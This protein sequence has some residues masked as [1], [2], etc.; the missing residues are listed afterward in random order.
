[1][2][3][4]IDA[5][6]LKAGVLQTT[7]RLAANPT[8]GRI[9]PYVDTRLIRDVAVE[10][11]WEQFG[12]S[13]ELRSDEP[14]GRGGGGTAPTSIRYFLSGIAFCLQVWYAKGAAL[15]G[16]ELESLTLR[17]EASFDMRVEYKLP[18]TSEHDYLLAS[19]VVGSP[20]DAAMV[21]AM[22]DE[23]HER[24]PLSSLVQRSLPVYRRLTH[25]G[26]LILDT[27]PADLAAELPGA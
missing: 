23:A 4:I 11:R 9:R 12:K 16:C 22:A 2:E 14:S 27:L 25:N 26:E 6:R 13:F 5:S 20:S 15:V 8:G 7:S 1:M 17:V 3:P 21:L 18:A 10:A 24:C 19:A